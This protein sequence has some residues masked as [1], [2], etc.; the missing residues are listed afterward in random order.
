MFCF[1]Y[2]ILESSIS[3][4]TPKHRYSIAHIVFRIASFIPHK[5][6]FPEKAFS[7]S[8]I[9][10][11]I[12]WTGS[13]FALV[14]LLKTNVVFKLLSLEYASS[15]PDLSSQHKSFFSCIAFLTR[16]SPPFCVF[17]LNTHFLLLYCLLNKHLLV[18]RSSS[19]TNLVFYTL[20][21]EHAFSLSCIISWICIFFFLFYLLNMHL[22]LPVLSPENTTFSLVLS[23]FLAYYIPCIVSWTSII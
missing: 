3:H 21:P 9:S 1:L 4:T 17:L 16:I 11:F 20:F 7:T 13:F 5:Y 15:V 22:L 18:P 14:C 23:T 2:Y 12:L 10:R 19:E 8:C 6:Y